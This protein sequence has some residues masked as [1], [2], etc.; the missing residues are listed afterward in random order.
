MNNYSI[1]FKSLRAGTVYTLNIGGGTGDAIPLKGGAQPFTTQEDDSDD[2]FTPIRTQTGYIRIMD[3]GFD[4]RTPAQAFDWKNL[5]PA[6]DTSRPVT[7]TA[8]GSVVWQGFMQAQNFGSVLYGG[9]Q[10]RDFPVQCPL[11]VLSTSY[12]DATN[13]ELKNFAYL[14]LQAFANLQGIEIDRFIFQGGLYAQSWLLKIVDWQNLVSFS[15]DCVTGAYDN[16]RIL[17]DIC[18][19]WG[20]TCR[21]HGKDV[22]FSAA[23]DTLL[24]NA[25]VLTSSQLST[26]AGGQ[27]VGTTN[28]AFLTEITMTGDIFA[29]INNENTVV[30]G[31][32]KAIVNTNANAADYTIMKLYPES[33]EKEMLNNGYYY[34]GYG[35]YY[36]NPLTGNAFS[37]LILVGESRGNYST[38]NLARYVENVNNYTTADVIKILKS[39]TSSSAD[40]YATI[41]TVFHHTFP[42]D[43]IP[44]TLQDKGLTLNAAIYFQGEKYENYN[45]PS[46]VG[47]NK[48]YIRLGIGTQ[49][50]IKW[51][52]GSG[53]STDK[54][55]FQVTLGNSGRELFYYSGIGMRT[56]I[57]LLGSSYE[58]ALHGRVY[59]EF[60][61]SDD[62]PESSGERS[63]DIL[64][65]SIEYVDTDDQQSLTGD[66]V[67]DS[68]TQY[69]ANN[70]SKML[71]EWNADL[72][73]AS[74]NNLSLGYGLVINT[75]YRFMEKAIYSSSVS[76]HPEQHLANRVVNY[77]NTPKRMLFVELLSNAGTSEGVVND[78]SPLNKVTIDGTTGYPISISHDW[79]DDI[80]QLTII[81]L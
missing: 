3:D 42:G 9:S 2:M 74:Q 33:V 37:S 60:L 31:Y 4:A 12:V 63:F 14:I 76:E 28:T 35:A 49:G 64:N 79:R 65:F 54:V 66:I 53:W 71:N 81:E 44:G 75:D 61:G 26:M 45:N 40:S 23:D 8:G 24:G 22:I 7:L 57:P 55:A 34:A 6:T 50:N 78:V 56:V 77:W 67:L 17:Q 32:N 5:L 62:M 72:I 59:V 36:S 38:F 21:V 68:S 19:F 41:S 27:A 69:I 16:L 48:M 25:L 11:S 52:S 46:G 1:T 18:Q 47:Q 13:R 30:R 20:W 15:K 43:Y 73:Y 51:F 29:S 58:E 80:T 10:E 39:F 70:Q